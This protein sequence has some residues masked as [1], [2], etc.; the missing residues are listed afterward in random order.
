MIQMKLEMMT[1]QQLRWQWQNNNHTLESI[2]IAKQNWRNAIFKT[3]VETGNMT[4]LE[5]NEKWDEAQKHYHPRVNEIEEENA[6]IIEL[7][8]ENKDLGRDAKAELKTKVE[9]IKQELEALNGN[10]LE[11]RVEEDGY[12]LLETTVE[13]L[14]GIM[15]YFNY[16]DQR[17]TYNHGWQIEVENLRYL[18]LAT[19]NALRVLIKNQVEINDGS[20]FTMKLVINGY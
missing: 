9:A 1:R 2:R 7:L 11:L 18:R 3:E 15:L 5:F 6:K 14:A 12:R 19:R 20:E 8:N 16:E 17:V 13:G 4:L 10:Q